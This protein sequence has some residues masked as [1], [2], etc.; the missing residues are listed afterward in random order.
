[1]KTVMWR[2]LVSVQVKSIISLIV[3]TW[4]ISCQLHPVDK[5]LET[6]TIETVIVPT[7]A[8]S[9]QTTLTPTETLTLRVSS[10]WTTELVVTIVPQPTSTGISMTPISSEQTRIV[11]LIQTDKQQ[12]RDLLYSKDGQFV[13]YQ[14]NTNEGGYE[15]WAIEIKTLMTHQ[16]DS[17]YPELDGS[18]HEILK[19]DQG[20]IFSVE[21]SPSGQ[22]VIYSRTPDKYF[23]PAAS[24]QGNG[25]FL[26][27][28][29]PTEVWTANIDG[30]RQRRLGQAQ[31]YYCPSLNIIGWFDNEN[32]ALLSCA[33][34]EGVEVWWV[35][36]LQENTLSNLS[37]DIGISSPEW[38]PGISVSSDGRLVYGDGIGHNW[39]IFSLNEHKVIDIVQTDLSLSGPHW[40]KEEKDLYFLG[41]PEWAWPRVFKIL[42][43]N[44]ETGQMDT[45]VDKEMLSALPW[46]YGG[47][48]IWDIA[49]DRR[50]AVFENTFSLWL[51][52]W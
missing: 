46:L 24:V 32:R 41:G 49:P 39:V 11:Q 47:A 8:L 50:S 48:V 33:L 31:D 30:S 1:M 51:V 2:Y 12:I 34:D 26:P 14:V 3:V 38:S 13:Y 18:I 4:L 43:Y 5:N 9:P 7:P 27:D 25:I 21:L 42:R 44:I 15:W 45:L 35:A 29:H 40:D 20:L 22:Q 28:L 23:P 52:E 17:P 19:P 36:D 10:T 6:R 37:S 16:I